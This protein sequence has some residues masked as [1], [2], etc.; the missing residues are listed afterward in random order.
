M[1]ELGAETQPTSGHIHARDD[2]ITEDFG[3]NARE[4]INLGSNVQALTRWFSRRF[5]NAH[6]DACE[7]ELGFKN[8]NGICPGILRTWGAAVLH[9]YAE[10]CGGSCRLVGAGGVPGHCGGMKW[11]IGICGS[12]CASWSGRVN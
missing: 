1:G 5:G 3:A 8:L 11:L 4:I 12:L 10:L 7:L 9:P 6:G 2:F